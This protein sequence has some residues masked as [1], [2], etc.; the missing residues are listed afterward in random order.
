MIKAIHLRIWRNRKRSLRKMAKQTKMSPWTMR[1]LVH[2]DLGMS[3]ALQKRQ[4]LSRATKQ[5][6]FERSKVLLNELK[7]AKAGETVWSDKKIFTIE[8]AHNRRNDGVIGSKVS[9]IP[10]KRNTVY[11]RM[12]P[13]SIMVW[14]GISKTWKS[15][16]IFVEENSKVNAKS[17]IDNILKPMLESV[18]NH[19]EDGTLNVSARR[20]HFSPANV[21]QNWCWDNLPRFWP[22]EMWPPYLPDLNSMDFS[23]W[24]TLEAKACSKV[25]RTVDDL[26]SSLEHAWQELQQEQLCASVKDVRRKLMAVIDSKGNHFE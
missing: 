16:L 20:S 21:T 12:K 23:I 17:Y 22:K 26:K 25:H 14:A 18:K 24:S 5:K 11:R 4:A 6:R 15:P 7:R 9:D 3:F 2:E 19:L 13:A 8:Q 1:R 10:Y